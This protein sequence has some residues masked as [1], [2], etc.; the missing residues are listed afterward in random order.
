MDEIAQFRGIQVE[1][2]WLLVCFNIK[3]I[4]IPYLRSVKLLNSI[5]TKTTQAS[6]ARRKHCIFRTV[7]YAVMQKR[8]LNQLRLLNFYPMFTPK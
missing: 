1:N 7:I 6:R 3:Y 4:S 2:T 5:T 8:V